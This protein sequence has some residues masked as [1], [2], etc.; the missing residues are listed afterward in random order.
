MMAIL[1]LAW[2]RLWL[3]VTFLGG[4]AGLFLLAGLTLR[5]K[6]AENIDP[7]LRLALESCCSIMGLQWLKTGPSLTHPARPRAARRK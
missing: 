2:G 4:A 5:G 6:L 3:A 1:G 7:G